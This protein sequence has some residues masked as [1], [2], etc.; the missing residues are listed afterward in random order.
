MIGLTS[1]AAAQVEPDG[2][3]A[4]ALESE[5]NTLKTFMVLLQ[6]E[7]QALVGGDIDAVGAL[8]PEK[9]LLAEQLLAFDAQRS[10]A[11][12]ARRLGAD[13]AGI[14]A[15]LQSQTQTITAFEELWR[16]WQEL[17]RDARTAQRIAKD[18]QALIEYRML[19]NQ[20]ALAVLQA[21]ASPDHVYVPDGGL[22]PLL[23]TRS[24]PAA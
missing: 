19:H 14:E 10:R 3:L 1:T 6:R 21:A 23:A 4:A 7:Q 13:R 2:D 9:G 8:G 18:N 11:L 12:A 16:V 17:V 5:R 20:R 24:H 15:W 22:R